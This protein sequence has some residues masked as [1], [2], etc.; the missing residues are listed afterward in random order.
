[1]VRLSPKPLTEED[2]SHIF[3]VDSYTTASPRRYGA[4]PTGPRHPLALVAQTG[5]C[6]CKETAR[7]GGRRRSEAAENRVERQNLGRVSI[8]SGNGAS[9]RKGC[10]V[11]SQMT[12]ASNK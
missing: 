9:S 12:K 7:K 1:M 4:E 6:F 2:I 10:V 5:A 8:R 11:N 3:V